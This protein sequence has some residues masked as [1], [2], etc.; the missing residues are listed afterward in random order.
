VL[1]GTGNDDRVLGIEVGKRRA[2]GLST[3]HEVNVLGEEHRKPTVRSM[4]ESVDRST[5]SRIPPDSRTIVV[6]ALDEL[7]FVDEV[8]GLSV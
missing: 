8:P 3:N 4:I 6:V 2:I 7:A 1:S 5:H